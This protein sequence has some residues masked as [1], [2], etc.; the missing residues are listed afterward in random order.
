MFD[1]ISDL[2]ARVRSMVAHGFAP[3]SR[4]SYSSG[5]KK[6]LK[7]CGLY[8][9]DP[10][11]VS[12]INL[13]RFVAYLA[14]CNLVVRT[15]R[16]YLSSIK[17]WFLTNGYPSPELFTPRVKLALRSVERDNPP[18]LQV[19]PLT[20]SILKGVFRFLFPSYDNIMLITAMSVAYY[21]CLRSAEYCHDSALAQGLSRSSVL[22]MDTSLTLSVPTSKTLLKGFNV[23]MGCSG[24]R[25]CAVCLMRLYLAGLTPSPSTPLFAYAD[26]SLLTYNRLSLFIKSLV[27]RMGLDPN[28]FSPHSLRA[29]AATDAATNGASS[30]VIQ[31]LGR[32]R[33]Q[34]YLA[35]LRPGH[36]EQASVSRLLSSSHR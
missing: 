30:H 35:Y 32:W 29:G 26:G 10:L 12:E 36:S 33:S 20:L 14:D 24:V 18:P 7:F 3:N 21:G 34:A 27:V 2:D 31:A 4:S 6:Y 17:S 15:I 16:V 28:K 25:F 1:I 13:L 23:V 9:L 8:R 22:L 5:F 11:G 19:A